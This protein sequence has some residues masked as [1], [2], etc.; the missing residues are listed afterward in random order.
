LK[1]PSTPRLMQRLTTSSA[2]R[3]AWLALDAIHRA[4]NQTANVDPKSS[5]TKGGFHAA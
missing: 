1:K 4:T 5:S 3:R 2:R